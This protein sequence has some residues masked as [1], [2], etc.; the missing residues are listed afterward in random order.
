[1]VFATDAPYDSR[2]GELLYMETVATIEGMKIS[3]AEKESIF[4]GNARNLFCL[5]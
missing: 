2:M 3:A 5:P 1:M 4:E